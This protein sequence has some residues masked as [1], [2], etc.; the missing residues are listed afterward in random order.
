MNHHSSPT[1]PLLRHAGRWA[2]PALAALLLAGGVEYPRRAVVVY[3]APPP[4]REEVVGVAPGPGYFWVR[5][6]WAWREGRYAWVGGRWA[7]APRAGVIWM[8]GHW[9][10]RGGSYV[11]VEGYWR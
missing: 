1:R 2:G 8:D 3:G 5:G 11:Y 7:A 10:N 6:H 9:E 4:V